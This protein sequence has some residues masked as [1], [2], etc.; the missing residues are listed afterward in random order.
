MSAGKYDFLKNKVQ[1]S[2]SHDKVIKQQWI[3]QNQLIEYK[4]P[5]KKPVAKSRS[6]F[7][8]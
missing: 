1:C 3:N 6:D 2:W 8:D 7:W 4:E 5:E